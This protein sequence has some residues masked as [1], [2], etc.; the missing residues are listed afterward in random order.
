MTNAL[1]QA[2]DED[3]AGDHPS[4][5]QEHVES[6]QAHFNEQYYELY[7]KIYRHYYYFCDVWVISLY[8]EQCII[9]THSEE[10]EEASFNW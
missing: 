6:T 10:E 5:H 9:M 7:E 3:P 8:L 2:Q 4:S 1:I